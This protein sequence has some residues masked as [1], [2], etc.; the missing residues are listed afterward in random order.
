MASRR[1]VAVVAAEEADRASAVA[2]FASRAAA[3]ALADLAVDLAAASAVDVAVRMPLTRTALTLQAE[4]VA[5]LSARVRLWARPAATAARP[6]AARSSSP[7]S[8]DRSSSSLADSARS[9]KCSAALTAIVRLRLSH[10]SAKPPR[11]CLLSGP[12]SCALRPS[13]P[14]VV[15][16]AHRP[17]PARLIRIAHHRHRRN[18]LTTR[19]LY[20]RFSLDALAVVVPRTT[21]VAASPMTWTLRYTEGSGAGDTI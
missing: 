21:A 16:C 7:G 1:A 5:A 15:R 11:Q 14:V 10:G 6:W 20:P 2:T 19:I 18:S 13:L 3:A 9:G 12:A 8:V 4:W 17:V